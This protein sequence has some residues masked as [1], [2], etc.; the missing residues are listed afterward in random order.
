MKRFSIL[1]LGLAVALM[2]VQDVDAKTRRRT[3]NARISSI[4]DNVPS[5]KE[6]REAL[7]Y[8]LDHP[9]L[10]K[11]GLSLLYYGDYSP[12][13]HVLYD[14]FIGKGVKVINHGKYPEGRTEIKATSP[15]AFYYHQ[16]NWD[17]GFGESFFFRNKEDCDNFYRQMV[18]EGA[19]SDDFLEYSLYTEDGWYNIIGIQP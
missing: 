15:H 16:G 4:T 6:F 8:L 11:H 5:Y 10:K 1:L 19:T 7:N 3:N 14:L 12:A 13:G 9:K 18:Q 2:A 17:G